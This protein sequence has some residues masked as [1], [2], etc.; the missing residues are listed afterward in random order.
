M[1][2]LYLITGPAGVGKS[3]ISKQI[4][5]NLNKSILIEGDDIYHLVKSGYVSAW[6]ENNHLK[7][8]WKN[9]ICLI[10]NGLEAGYDVVFNYI[11]N[12]KDYEMLKEKFNKYNIIF[13]V[14]IVSEEELIRRDNLRDIDCRMKERCIVLLNNFKKQSFNKENIIDTTNLTIKETLNKIMEVK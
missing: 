10:E 4:A 3:T 14:L 8:F 13:K 5:Q 12:K 9:V 2:T 11:I 7:L 1:S 6:M